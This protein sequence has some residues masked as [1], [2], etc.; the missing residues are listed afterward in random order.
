MTSPAQPIT[1]YHA[2]LRQLIERI[3]RVSK[4]EFMQDRSA[5]A[6]YLQRTQWVL[7]ALGNPERQI[8]HYIHVGGTSGKGSTVAMMHNIIQAAGHRVGSTYSPHLTSFTE[9][10][11][12]NDQCISPTKFSTIAFE[13]LPL[14]DRCEK[15]SPYGMI[16]FFELMFIMT[17]MHFAREK[18]EYAVI[19]VG[20]GGRYDASNLIPTPDV[21]II[22]N[23]GSDHWQLIGPT[24]EDIAQE[25]A[26][27][28]KEGTTLIH[29][30]HEPELQAVLLRQCEGEKPRAIIEPQEP[31]QVQVTTAG[32]SFTYDGHHYVV[33]AIGAHQA[34][35]AG[36][37]IEAARALHLP[38]HA[39]QQGLAATVRPGCMERVATDPTIYI[40]GAHNQEKMRSTIAA[41]QAVV[42]P[43]SPVHIVLAI[44]SD[45]DARALIQD[46]AQCA[47]TITTT[48]YQPAGGKQPFAA[49]ALA[50]IAK[51]FLPAERVQAIEDAQ[52]AFAAVLART[53]KDATLV[54]TGSLYLAGTIRS[55]YVSE[56]DILLHGHTRL[57]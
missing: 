57:P 33:P 41:I 52:V 8:P 51:E 54:V 19:E 45:K 2:C 5:C 46:L 12:V 50:E 15:E 13:L 40:D 24:R 6:I 4:K 17:L 11:V 56:D 23:I 38:D 18:V 30:I 35:N 7:D 3:E 39:I 20:M 22:T 48:Q 55:R 28:I 16:S 37:A 25:K 47:T 1:V 14:L 42:P 32:T 44:S 21:T 26:G 34:T 49:T 36:F 31:T 10:F 27:I 9:R 29:G 43:T 53:S